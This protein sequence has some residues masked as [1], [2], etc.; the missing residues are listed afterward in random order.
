MEEQ[1][2]KLQQAIAQVR[3]EMDRLAE[4]RLC[5]VRARVCVCVCV[6]V[7]R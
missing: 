2:R 3:K 5:A 6:C 7:S 4:S 1:R